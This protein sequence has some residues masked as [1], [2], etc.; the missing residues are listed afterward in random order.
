MSRCIKILCFFFLMSLLS[1]CSSYDLHPQKPFRN[2][3][4]ANWVNFEKFKNYKD[5][6]KVYQ[7][8]DYIEVFKEYGPHKICYTQYLNYLYSLEMNGFIN[9]NLPAKAKNQMNSSDHWTLVILDTL[10]KKCILYD[11][12]NVSDYSNFGMTEHFIAM[13]CYRSGYWCVYQSTPLDWVTGVL[14]INKKEPLKPMITEYLNAQP[15]IID[16]KDGL[17]RV[18]VNLKNLRIDFFSWY[19]SMFSEHFHKYMFTCSDNYEEYLYSQDL[20]LVSRKKI[21][22]EIVMEEIKSL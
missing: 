3:L 5:F 17:L 8:N 12:I 7:Y 16:E 14:I 18:V 11:T 22:K 21:N 4:R 9:V 2:E 10:E 13:D 6:Y 1:G 15:V 20:K 19:F